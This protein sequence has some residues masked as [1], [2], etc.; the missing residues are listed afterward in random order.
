[1]SNEPM[2]E[3]TTEPA[4]EPTTTF[5]VWE[6]GAEFASDVAVIASDEGDFDC[7]GA[8]KEYALRTVNLPT[9]ELVV[10]RVGGD[11]RAVTIDFDFDMSTFDNGK[12]VPCDDDEL[13]PEPARLDPEP[14]WRIVRVDNYNDEGPR[15]DQYIAAMA[16]SR[17]LA[18]KICEL[19]NAEAGERSCDYF[20]VVTH[21]YK[22]KP[23]F[24]P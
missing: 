23:D 16:R 21:D 6:H 7:E 2:T 24:Q 5:R 15:G 20:R 22:L 19:M 1:M 17:E 3:S 12:L 9:L 11:R 10:Q 13:E 8:A 14:M 18:V 4:T